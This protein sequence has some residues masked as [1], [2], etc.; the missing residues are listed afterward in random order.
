[1][2]NA[3]AGEQSPYLLQ[4]AGN[5]V[6]WRPWSDEAFKLAREQDKLVFLSVGYSTCHWCHVMAHESFESN[7]VA[8]VLN[9]HFINVKLDREERPD[10]DA[11]Y[12]NYLQLTTGQ[13]GWPMSLW[14][15]CE[16]RPVFGA[17][18]FPAE[19]KH[20]RAGLIRIAHELA[21][22]WRDDRTK[23]LEQGRKVMQHL[24]QPPE[25]VSANPIQVDIALDDFLENCHQ[26]FDEQNGGFG[27]APKFPRPVILDALM[28]LAK[29]ESPLDPESTMAWR[30][31]HRT[32]QA[33][34][35]GGMYDH[36]GGGF[37]R[38]SVDRFWHVPH[39]EKML[40]DQGQLALCYLEAW[41]ISG[42]TSLRLVAEGSL[43]YM[44]DTLS[45]EGGAFHAA[46]DA[47]SFEKEGDD[48]AIEGA[49]WTW[50]DEDIQK[51]L[52]P[53]AAAVFC[54]AYGVEAQGNA[55]PESD[56]HGEL[57]GRNTLHRIRSDASLADT[58]G[59]SIREI[60]ASLKASH[61]VL[62]NA[63]C[64]RPQPHR[65]DKI[66]TAW[67]GLA[68]AAFARGG[69]L[70]D[71]SKWTRKAIAAAEFIRKQLQQD[72]QLY[73]S[74]RK[75]VSPAIAVAD[76]Y[77]FLIYGLLELHRADTNGGW[78]AWI[79]ELQHQLDVKLWD[80]ERQG[81]VMRPQLDGTT[82]MTLRSDYDGAEPSA[83]HLSILNLEQ[84]VELT[85]EERYKRRIE[86]LMQAGAR[87]LEHTFA[88]PVLIKAL[89]KRS[90]RIHG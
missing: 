34:A 5:P 76:D 24:Q 36:L 21:R 12:M 71:E 85:G 56:P 23:L 19:D 88:V 75:K 84:L 29:R 64:R 44:A 35:Q 87:C 10:I 50:R 66:I 80:E 41:E 89:A 70:L 7:K 14:L 49:Y 4:H 78:L 20:G 2:P 74:W 77:V 42:D 62:A 22:V 30:M 69:R 38:Y 51:L 13:G 6:N 60:Q 59:D 1:M 32:L 82:L 48:H 73:R 26:R 40:Y 28:S 8:E 25:P 37:H 3:L 31:T 27:G 53:K 90:T 61:D 46:E 83:N 65:D 18:Y 55:R 17:T 72:G 15:D 45:D 68:I 54:A 58:F 39:Y 86:Q 81:Y 43:R 63:R 9:H 79:L 67:N 47:D 16:G 11:L 33:M 52:D 57:V